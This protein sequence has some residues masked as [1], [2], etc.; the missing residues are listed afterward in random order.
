[1]SIKLR[2]VH[3]GY[4]GLDYE[5]FVFPHPSLVLNAQK[6]AGQ[7]VWYHCPVLSFVIEHPNG[8][9][10]WDTGISTELPA[11]WPPEWQWLIDLNEITPEVC[12]EKRLKQ[13]NLGPDD[14]RYV[15]QSHLHCDHAGGLRLFESAGAE[16]I[17][18]EAEYRHVEQMQAAEHFFVPADFALLRDLKKP[19]LVAGDEEF[20]HGVRLVNLPGHTP[21][22]MGLLV[23]LDRTGWVLLAADAMYTHDSY[24]PPAVGSPITADAA[25][26]AEPMRR[27][28]EWLA[29]MRLSSCLGTTRPRSSN[30]GSTRNSGRSSSRR[31]MSMSSGIEAPRP[32]GSAPK[33]WVRNGASD[34][35][36]G[37]FA[38]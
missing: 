18:H 13:L 11:E 21:G 36:R 20:M 23:D 37:Q 24:G 4:M 35:T 1:M 22:S 38:P 12:L 15:I 14:F 34:A 25:K 17:V 3:L 9:I 32:K 2:G 28:A 6:Q 33:P 30:T 31:G 27:F 29:S 8:L 19:T 10:L 5:L 26:W 7:K 16:I